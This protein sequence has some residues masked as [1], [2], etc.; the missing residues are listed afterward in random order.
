MRESTSPTAPVVVQI[1]DISIGGNRGEYPTTLM[2]STFH[3]RD[4]I[5]SNHKTGQFNDERS[6]GR[7]MNTRSH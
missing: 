6:S 1:G 2:L 5:V 3:T 4:P 7:A